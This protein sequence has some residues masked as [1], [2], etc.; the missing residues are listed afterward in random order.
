[1]A[2]KAYVN[3]SDDARCYK[4]TLITPY[5]QCL[6]SK[7]HLQSNVAFLAARILGLYEVSPVLPL[8]ELLGL[9]Q[10]KLYEHSDD[11]AWLRHQKGLEMMILA[12]GPEA[13]RQEHQDSKYFGIKDVSM[14]SAM[15]TRTRSFFALE[16]W[17]VKK[18]E[19]PSTA[20]AFIEAVIEIGLSYTAAVA[21]GNACVRML[22][23]GRLSSEHVSKCF[24]MLIDVERR[25]GEWFADYR[26]WAEAPIFTINICD[27]SE[28][29]SADLREVP[30]R[31]EYTFRSLYEAIAMMDYWTLQLFVDQNIMEL[32]ALT[33]VPFVPST[34][35]MLD[36][37]SRQTRRLDLC[38][39][40]LRS[41]SPLMRKEMGTV[42]PIRCLLPFDG[43]M[44]VLKHERGPA[45]ASLFRK[46]RAIHFQF[47]VSKGLSMV[48]KDEFFVRYQSPDWDDASQPRP[49]IMLI[50]ECGSA[51]PLYLDWAAS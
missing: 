33:G 37:E 50:G 22:S 36:V 20:T 51:R 34:P 40:I 11:Y 15:S 13:Y 30:D 9:T 2:S 25:L 32:V 42:G 21:E 12:R 28:F 45:A 26:A 46:G 19:P 8:R 14:M 17:Q 24:N 48:G 16:Q 35:G 41:V 49:R 4:K 38:A 31:L 18:K 29:A 7:S 1:M 23:E 47:L 10:R 27:D 43:A 39:H 5:M 6:L 44:G 3:R